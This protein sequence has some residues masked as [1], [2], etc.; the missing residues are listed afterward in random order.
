[1]KDRKKIQNTWLGRKYVSFFSCIQKFCF[2]LVIRYQMKPIN[3]EIDE[4]P[5]SYITK[6]VN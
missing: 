4:K 5:V 6:S 1:M 2:L 3:H